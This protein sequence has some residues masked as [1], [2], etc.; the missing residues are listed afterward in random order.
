MLQITGN[1]IAEVVYTTNIELDASHRWLCFNRM[2]INTTKIKCMVFG[3][4]R[5]YRRF[6]DSGLRFL[7]STN[8]EAILIVNQIKYLLIRNLLDDGL[9]IFIYNLVKVV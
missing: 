3:S 7:F 9:S 8:K 2:K 4:K 5:N 1:D 6:C